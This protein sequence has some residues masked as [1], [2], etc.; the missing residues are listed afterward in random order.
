MIHDKSSGYY[1]YYVSQQG[2]E[3]PIFRGGQHGAGLG[4][5][6]RGILRFIAPVALRGLSI[7]AS[8]TISARDKGAS[9]SDAARGATTPSLS[10]MAEQFRNNPRQSGDGDTMFDGEHGVPYKLS[11]THKS[12]DAHAKE[13]VYKSSGKRKF[14]KQKGSNKD[15]AK[16]AKLSSDS[17]NF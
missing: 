8:S 6:L 9:F 3:L 14:G 4:D 12:N 10:A 1:K 15:K 17:Y 11:D 7:F 2:G 13:H 5:I 16:H